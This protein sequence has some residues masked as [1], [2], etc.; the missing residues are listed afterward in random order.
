[1]GATNIGIYWVLQYYSD[2]A[3]LLL[4]IIFGV[5]GARKRDGYEKHVA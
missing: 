3:P 4:Q 5:W 1:M 2:S